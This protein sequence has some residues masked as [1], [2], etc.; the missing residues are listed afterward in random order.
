M[1]INAKR[2]HF[3][4]D[5][6]YI[7]M[8]D[9][10]KA[11][12]NNNQSKVI[13]NFQKNISG[14]LGL[15]GCDA[16]QQDIMAKLKSLNEEAI[17]GELGVILEELEKRNNDGKWSGAIV[18]LKVGI[19]VLSTREEQLKLVRQ[20]NNT[21]GELSD[22]VNEDEKLKKRIGDVQSALA[23]DEL[24]DEQ[25]KSELGAILEEL[26]KRHNGGKWSGAIVDLKVGIGVL[27][28]REEQLK[29]VRQ[30]N[31]TLKGVYGELS[32]SVNEDKKLKKEIELAILVLSQRNNIVKL[33]EQVI[34]LCKKRDGG[35]AQSVEKS[36]C[37]SI[38]RMEGDIF[39]T[40][41][42]TFLSS[43]VAPHKVCSKVDHSLDLKR[44]QGE[45]FIKSCCTWLCVL[46]LLVFAFCC[47]T[48]IININKRQQDKY[49][50][51]GKYGVAYNVSMSDTVLGLVNKMLEL[52]SGDNCC[53]DITGRNV[54][55][56]ERMEGI[57]KKDTNIEPLQKS[58]SVANCTDFWGWIVLLIVSGGS[59]VF[60][61]YKLSKNFANDNKVVRE[62]YAKNLEL[63]RKMRWDSFQ[64]ELNHVKNIQQ[65]DR[66]II[67]RIDKF[68]NA[69]IDET[70][71]RNEHQ[72]ELAKK[73][74]ELEQE[75]LK[76]GVELADKLK[77][78]QI[79]YLRNMNDS[80]SSKSE[81]RGDSQSKS[82]ADN[83]LQ[84]DAKAS[85][86]VSPLR[87]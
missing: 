11:D 30:I 51:A 57:S 73:S 77:D 4:V 72:R 71:K 61:F 12:L 60:C 48:M 9:N 43:I 24:S 31:N 53:I 74:Y 14:L 7:D 84:V 18:D 27:S 37:E 62:E 69:R 63:W 5:K 17:V 80:A 19:G 52:D 46:A 16:S 33:N 35:D 83:N 8:A 65:E 26:E 86:T 64:L 79:A 47:V 40:K 56:H 68:V 58:R 41:T 21:L 36:T 39:D 28:T 23:S 3:L 45:N 42:K 15:Q 87:Q 54:E 6:K 78:I 25:K 55:I 70:V 50:Q 32:D 67:E 2:Y 29:L 1:F 59:F 10:Q 44:P 13:D 81:T 20:I 85:V 38:D 76:K 34:E 66:L 82:A 49:I 22:S 75:R